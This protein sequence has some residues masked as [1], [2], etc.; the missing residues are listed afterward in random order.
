MDQEEGTSHA[1]K[2][3]C[4]DI[5]TKGILRLTGYPRCHG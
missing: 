5:N 3:L 1:E 2:P 4:T